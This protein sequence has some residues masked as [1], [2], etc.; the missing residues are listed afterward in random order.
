MVAHR[1][2]LSGLAVGRVGCIGDSICRPNTDEAIYTQESADLTKMERFH[3]PP[4]A[5][6]SLVPSGETWQL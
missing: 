6:T 4:A 1:A 2:Q 3:S 5:V